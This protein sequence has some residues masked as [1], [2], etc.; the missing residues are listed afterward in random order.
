M[1]NF[2]GCFCWSTEEGE[3]QQRVWF[4][5]PARVWSQNSVKS[6]QKWLKLTRWPE[7]SDPRTWCQMSNSKAYLMASLKD[8]YCAIRKHLE[9][10]RAPMWTL[11]TVLKLNRADQTRTLSGQTVHFPS[12]CS[13]KKTTF[14]CW[15]HMVAMWQPRTTRCAG[16]LTPF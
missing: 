6:G 10:V 11:I 8:K 14:L 4:V 7:F 16:V 1:S 13:L 5:F 15:T 9:S 12:K 2:I 3:K